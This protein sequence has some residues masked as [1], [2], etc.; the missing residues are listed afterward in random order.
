MLPCW[1]AGQVSI[2]ALHLQRDMC[3]GSS[4]R[5]TFGERNINTV[6]VG[7]QTA[8]LGRSERIFLPDG[9]EC[10]GSCSYRSPVNFTDF[11]EDA[12]ITSVENIKYVRL[13][14]EHSYIGDIYINITCPNNKKADIM[15]FAGSGTS[16]C[17]A[18]IP[19]ESRHWLSGN[20]IDESSYFGIAHDGENSS[21][22][23]NPE[24]RGNQP[25]VGWNYCWSSNTTSGYHY[26]SGDG[27]VYRSGHSHNGRVDSS[28]VA[29]Q[30]N[31][32]RP[33][34]SFGNL[35]GCPL[36]GTWYIEVVDGFSVD[37]GYIFEWELSLE[38]TLLPDDCKP[39]SYM[40]AGDSVQ[41][42]NDTTFMLRAPDVVGTD[43][44]VVYRFMV[45]TTCG[46]TIDTTA[47][48]TFHP[49]EEVSIAD[50]IC[51]GDDYFVGSYHVDSSVTLIIPTMAGCDSTVHLDLTVHP[52]Y[53]TVV[54]DSTC[55]HVPYPFEGSTYSENGTYTHRLQT[56][57]GCDSIRTLQLKVLSKNLRAAIYAFPLVV[58]E[59]DNE[60]LLKDVSMNHVGSRWLIGSNTFMESEMQFSYPL[61][62]D[63]LE[64]SLEAKS[65][66]GCYDTATVIARYD[67]SRM[68]IPNAFTP[69]LEQDDVWRP[70]MQDV[71]EVE[72]WIYSRQGVLVA[73]L[74][75]VDDA[76]D[77][78]DWP[79]G[80]YTYFMRF[81]TRAHPGWRQERSG[82]ILMI[83]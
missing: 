12:T 63:S 77:G 36:N 10:N 26:A 14:L 15:R 60:I 17:D 64:I 19:Q 9:V 68:F 28:N 37:N 27:I 18:T 61:P 3:A 31:F 69:S 49:N 35:V 2:K 56:I 58:D 32:Y 82:T 65:R 70:V 67:H 20:N 5:I 24:A 42:L 41:K 1:A 48:I 81:R 7:R 45:I 71:V 46:D 44:A 40:V 39:E 11:A 43:T 76:W 72:I 52:R 62:L 75:G 78:G 79:Q 74:N 50:T 66:E 25:G 6:V 23:C 30:T 47:T 59:N 29:A 21:E 4:Q 53:D 8:T 34:D 54:R 16:S 83:R 80:I 73:H 38:A 13:N 51:E 33:D 55:L 57:H 22:P